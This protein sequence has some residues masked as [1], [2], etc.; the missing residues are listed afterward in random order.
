MDNQAAQVALGL[1]A[2]SWIVGVPLFIVGERH[3]D[4]SPRL[5]ITCARLH[6]AGF[7]LLAWS[8]GQ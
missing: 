1:I 2:A 3:G 7:F 6:L 8:I 5:V 4:R